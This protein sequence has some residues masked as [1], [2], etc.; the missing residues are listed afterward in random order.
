MS[1]NVTH[2]LIQLCF[3]LSY[4]PLLNLYLAITLSMRHLFY[5]FLAGALLGGCF[6]EKTEQ[7]ARV[8]PMEV[9]ASYLNLTV[10]F[11]VEEL[12]DGIN[13]LLPA[14]LMDKGLPLNSKGDTAFV[15]IIKAGELDLRFR[16]NHAYAS[17]PIKV[18]AHIRKK[19]MGVTFSNE[20][21][22]LEFNAIAKV[23]SEMILTKDWDLL[24][25]CNWVELDWTDNPNITIL[26]INLDLGKKLDKA[27]KEN[28]SEISS[29]LCGEIN[30]KLKFR[31]TITKVWEDIQKPIR[32]AQK[33]T[34]LWLWSVPQSLNA[35]L[36][37]LKED[38]LSIAVELRATLHASPIKSK[39]KE[40]QPLP[41]RSEPLGDT[42]GMVSFLEMNAP[43]ALVEKLVAEQLVGSE[44]TF[45]DYTARILDIKL[46]SEGQNLKV[47]AKVTGSIIGKIEISGKPTLTT[48]GKAQLSDFTYSVELDDE[49]ATATDWA[50]H[51]FAESYLAQ[52][53]S[54][55]ASR[56]L[57]NLDSLAM[58]GIAKSK[59]GDKLDLDLDLKN[60]ESYQMYLSEKEIQW[61]FY[62]EG[63]A[64][65]VLKKGL[66][67]SPK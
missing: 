57:N 64:G 61:I 10:N 16:G 15:K 21:T 18:K 56:I 30:S 54:F 33:P 7:S 49:M 42:P 39:P 46:S 43:I 9:P 41:P 29:K 51:Q 63:K 2:S 67:P 12:T 55:D 6:A 24:L 19:V 50:L 28:Q 47:L 35:K 23:K 52:K 4:F 62:V 22:P 44:Y 14:I 26:G 66:F 60:V 34:E 20:A 31:K 59:I 36:L 17:L 53:V 37:P 32:I 13:N 58:A 27:I 1:K 40:P 8:G 38:K 48:S 65:I 45:Q 5:L 3:V 25:E 11:P